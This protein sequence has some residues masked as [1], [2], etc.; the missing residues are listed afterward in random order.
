MLALNTYAIQELRWQSCGIILVSPFSFI[1]FLV[2]HKSFTVSSGWFFFSFL[3]FFLPMFSFSFLIVSV[4]L[5]RSTCHAVPKL[6]GIQELLNHGTRSLG[7]ASGA[8][9]CWVIP[10]ACSIVHVFSSCSLTSDRLPVSWGFLPVRPF[11]V[12]SPYCLPLDMAFAALSL[13]ISYFIAWFPI[14]LCMQILST[15]LLVLWI[16]L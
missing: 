9:T 3:F 12:F 13:C 15:F 16:L 11:L 4:C 8:F 7:W 5:F 2:V 14:F 10:Q 6:E 1:L